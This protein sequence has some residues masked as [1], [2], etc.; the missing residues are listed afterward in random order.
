M[1][2]RPV[3][4]LKGAHSAAPERLQK[5]LAKSGIGSR[6]HLEDRI[7]QGDIKVDGQPATL[8][9]SVGP[10]AR[11]EVDGKA[12]LVRQVER[13]GPRV[14]VYNKPEGEVTTRQDPD[15]RPTVFDRLPKLKGSRWIA[16]GRLDLNTAGLLLLTTDG[17]LAN[18]LMHPSREIDRE[19]LC[20]VH[21]DVD[22]NMVERLLDGVELDDGPARFEE[23]EPVAEATG[24]NSWF[25]CLL[26]EGRQREVRR[27]WDA[28]GLEVS[29]L[30]RVRYGPVELGKDLKR[31]WYRDLT[32]EEVEKLC[33]AVGL[34]VTG[35]SELRLVPEQ[36]L[37][38][39]DR[40]R[41]GGRRPPPREDWRRVVHDDGDAERGE[42]RG[43]GR[44][45]FGPGAHPKFERAEPRSEERRSFEGQAR[46]PAGERSERG[47]TARRSYEDRPRRDPRS[48]GSGTG[49]RPA[50]PAWSKS[51]Q[52][53]RPGSRPGS[54]GGDARAASGERRQ[55]SD[56][57][58][59]G[60][61]ERSLRTAW[62]KSEARSPAAR[63]PR[64]AAES[65][66]GYAERS[67]RGASPG[68]SRDAR[69]P[70]AA[71]SKS[72]GARAERPAGSTARRDSRGDA[73]RPA[74]PRGAGRGDRTAGA[75]AGPR[76]ERAAGAGA[77]YKG[78]PRGES[79]G[80]S[81]RPRT[82]SAGPA[83]GAS[84]GPRRGA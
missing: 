74:G 71:W 57:P 43:R 67:S 32:P 33:G 15:G 61:D 76:G 78:G 25:R 46:R 53:P 80:G 83:K 70:R 6:R 79:R 73:A 1:K 31:G 44:D 63:G 59:R 40:V 11:I 84:R 48:E 50:R 2:A 19:Y 55:R 36:A 72:E 49:E 8:G 56:A 23:L 29:R 81:D 9:Q 16:V 64:G 54:R 42:R 62:S 60:A 10:G 47:P 52:A 68:G 69:P 35:F 14:L 18:L 24:S 37:H 4:K 66:G 38:K 77:G 65:R 12:F 28:V 7:L 51:E 5:I 13:M 30:K 75:G 3:L 21:G 82:R 45:G 22:G 41:R 26:R 17:E 20:R 58:P 34:T 39:F 27:L